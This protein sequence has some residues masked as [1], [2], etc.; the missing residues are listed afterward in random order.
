MWLNL[1]RRVG[2]ILVM[3]LVMPGFAA[4]AA[5]ITCADHS[6]TMNQIVASE[7]NQLQGK[8]AMALDC[9][10]SAHCALCFSLLPTAITLITPS[11]EPTVIVAPRVT[12]PSL[13]PMP[14]LQ[15]PR[16]TFSQLS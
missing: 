8:T 14:E 10:N 2:L 4:S 6:Q 9:A 15:P 7:S 5:Q 16:L 11:A 13:T 1:C 12:W 3:M